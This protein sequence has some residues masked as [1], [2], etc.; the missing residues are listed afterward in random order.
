MAPPAKKTGPAAPGGAHLTAFSPDGGRFCAVP[1]HRPNSFAV[2]AQDA[3][4]HRH[5]DPTEQYTCVAW[6]RG[7]GQEELVALG[8]KSGKVQVRFL[9]R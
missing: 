7:P 5:Q 3:L 8:C 6:L 4:E 1:A 2:F 9:S